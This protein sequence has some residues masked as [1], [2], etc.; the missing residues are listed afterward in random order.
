M[1]M[2]M[3]LFVVVVGENSEIASIVAAVLR[4][5]DVGGINP[6]ILAASTLLS[7]DEPIIF[8][9][10]DKH[11]FHINVPPPCLFINPKRINLWIALDETSESEAR[12]NIQ[13]YGPAPENFYRR[14][15]PDPVVMCG[16]K[17]PALPAEKN[18]LDEWLD[19]LVENLEPWRK[20]IWDAF[21]ASS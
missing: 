19:Y 12:K 21:V 7:R 13:E 3:H 17:I 16:F 6:K 20:R 5:K 9:E 4:G 10:S 15:F 1:S 14:V 18:E 8:L 2:P 11:K